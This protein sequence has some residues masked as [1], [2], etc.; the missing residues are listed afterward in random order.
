MALFS[1]M[2][3]DERER[4]LKRTNEGRRRRRRAHEDG[5]ATEALGRAARGNT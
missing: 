3:E 5:A 1:A 4:I 2:A